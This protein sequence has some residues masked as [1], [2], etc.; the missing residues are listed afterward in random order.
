VFRAAQ[1][2]AQRAVIVLP[3]RPP[4]FPTF[5]VTAKLEQE[6]CLAVVRERMVL[7]EQRRLVELLNRIPVAAE[8]GEA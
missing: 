8:F 4:F 2:S 1:L 6:E 5:L 3:R 7:V